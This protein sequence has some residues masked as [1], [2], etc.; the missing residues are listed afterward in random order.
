MDVDAM[1]ASVLAA[2]N[3]G[4]GYAC[5]QDISTWRQLRLSV[6]QS[7]VICL[8]ITQACV[9]C[10]TLYLCVR[11]QLHKRPRV[12]A[13]QLVQLCEHTWNQWC[14]CCC[15]RARCRSIATMHASRHSLVGPA[16]SRMALPVTL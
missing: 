12:K 6:F 15:A 16:R 4:V 13:W 14:S 11:E 7:Q 9:I 2:A 5:I 3:T 1:P 8:P 10:S